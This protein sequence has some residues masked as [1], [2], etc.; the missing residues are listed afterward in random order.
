MVLK[1]HNRFHDLKGQENKIYT[2]VKDKETFY[3]S[4]TARP[5]AKLGSSPIIFKHIFMHTHYVQE[6]HV[7]VQIWHKDTKLR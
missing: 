3:C 5:L 2:I 6:S 4:H 1:F 7:L